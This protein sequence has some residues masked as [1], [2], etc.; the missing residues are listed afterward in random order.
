MFDEIIVGRPRASRNG[1]G[2]DRFFLPP[3]LAGAAA[4]H[5]P[6]PATSRGNW[7]KKGQQACSSQ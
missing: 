7:K 2:R 4:A 3:L 1:D 5:L 6:Q